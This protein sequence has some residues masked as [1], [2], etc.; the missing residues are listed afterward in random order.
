[1]PRHYHVRLSRISLGLETIVGGYVRGQVLTSLLI[2]GFTFAVLTIAGAPNAI[3]IAVFAGLTDVLPYIG[4]LLA[5]GPAVL[6]T[7]SRGPTAT[8][9]VLVLLVVYQEFESR[10]IVPRS[11]GK[12]SACR[13]P[14]SS[15]RLLAGGKLLAFSAHCSRFR[16]RRGYDWSS[17]SSGSICRAN[18]AK[19]PCSVRREERGE[20]EYHQRTEGVPAQQAARWR[21]RSRKRL[22]TVTVPPAPA[23]AGKEPPSAANPRQ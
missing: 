5:T 10:V 13:R 12:R 6:A 1:V 20:R 7:L 3:A 4:G 15:S 11:M 17:K 22:D 14:S 8:I 18:L 16:L 9:V 21:R 23:E 2:A 19:I